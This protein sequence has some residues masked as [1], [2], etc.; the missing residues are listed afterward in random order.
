MIRRDRAESAILVR[1]GR[2]EDVQAM[3]DTILITHF[4]KF[5]V[6]RFNAYI[7]REWWRNE[8]VGPFLE[9]QYLKKSFVE[10]PHPEVAYGR[11]IEY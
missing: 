11:I 8:D 2:G 10:D 9:V 3:S 7:N 4:K 5:K 6:S 1:Q